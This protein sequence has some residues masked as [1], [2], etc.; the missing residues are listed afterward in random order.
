MRHSRWQDSFVQR[1]M[2]RAKK[3]GKMDG[4][5][6]TSSLKLARSAGLEPTTPSFGNWYSIQMSYER[7]L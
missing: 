4:I 5:S 1:E 6:M 3:P 2:L 7:T